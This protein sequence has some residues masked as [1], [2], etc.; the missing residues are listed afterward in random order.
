VEWAAL[1]LARAGYVVA[2]VRP[3]TAT[4]LAYSEAARI[5][6]D[7]ML[8]PASPF[9][10]ETDARRVGAAGWSLGARALSKNQAEDTRIDAIVAWDN[11]ATSEAGDAGSPSVCQTGRLLT[12][13]ARSPRV[14]SLGQASDQCAT[15]QP[16]E[17]KKTAYDAWRAAGVPAMELV[18]ANSSHFFWSSMSSEATH[19]LAHHYTLAWFDRWV[20]NDQSATARLLS[21]AGSAGKPLA[22]VLSTRFTSAAFL[23]GRDCPDLRA[24]C[25]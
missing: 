16:R 6:I 11:L 4:P 10:A 8:S 20:K 24:A 15:S 18:F 17:S 13:P 1:R 19:E 2:T 7:Y 9:A 3:A 14:P 5:E 25:D 12:G 21:R 23:D 22:D